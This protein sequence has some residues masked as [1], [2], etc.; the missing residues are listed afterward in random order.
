MGAKVT[1]DLTAFE[2]L[3]TQAPV[4]GIVTLNFKIDVYSDGKEDWLTDPVL[5]RSLFPIRGVG[6]DPVP[7]GAMLDPTFFIAAP[8]KIR[9]YDADHEL[10]VVG[11][12]YRDDGVSIF[13]P[14][15]SRTIVTTLVTTF[16]AG[17]SVGDIAAAVLDAQLSNHR[18]PGSY[19]LS[20]GR[21]RRV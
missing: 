20:A 15:D 7:G 11:N 14:R 6:G 13:L 12:V 4:D 8:W 16:S 5:P 18:I 17:A 10:I 2:I 9:P 19:G 1:F 21:I 3:V